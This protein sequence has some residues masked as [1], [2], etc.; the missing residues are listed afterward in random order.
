MQPSRTVVPTRHP[1]Q[2][3]RRGPRRDRKQDPVRIPDAAQL[4]VVG[5]FT[6]EAWVDVTGPGHSGT[7]TVLGKPYG[8]GQV[9]TATVWFSAGAFYAAVN[10]GGTSGAA[11][12]AWPFGNGT[13][14]HVAWTFDAASQEET[15]FVDGARVRARSLT[16]L[17]PTTST[18][19]LVSRGTPAGPGP[20]R[21]GSP[22]S[23]PP[24]ARQSTPVLPMESTPGWHRPWS[25]LPPSA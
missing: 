14:H 1:T 7:E 15:L 6:M 2:A 22:P 10:L 17:R 18:G 9:D 20:P 13:W 5:S 24:R 23:C 12:Y 25:S 21:H 16:T 4:D 3:S 8:S 19:R 11:S